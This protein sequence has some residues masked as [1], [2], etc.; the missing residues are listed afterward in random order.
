MRFTR[1]S[2]IGTMAVAVIV[3]VAFTLAGGTTTAADL[4]PANERDVAPPPETAIAVHGDT[5]VYLPM[6]HVS[7]R[8]ATGQ[9]TMHRP[10]HQG[11]PEPCCWILCVIIDTQPGRTIPMCYKVCEI[12][13]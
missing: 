8:S 9:H 2:L 11:I 1:Y 5:C 7:V 12:C 4:A 13:G 3:A 10:Q 6:A